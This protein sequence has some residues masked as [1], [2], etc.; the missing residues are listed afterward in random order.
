[1]RNMSIRLRGQ[2]KRSMTGVICAVNEQSLL[3]GV[4]AHFLAGSL[5]CIWPLVQDVLANGKKKM[6]KICRIKET[7]GKKA[8][9]ELSVSMQSNGSGS[10]AQMQGCLRL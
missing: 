9:T 6:T 10:D 1:M 3:L 7:T 8:R 5:T 4:Q 2:D